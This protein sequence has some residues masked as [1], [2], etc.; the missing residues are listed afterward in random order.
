MEFGPVVTAEIGLRAGDEIAATGRL[1]VHRRDSRECPVNHSVI[2][3]VV[4]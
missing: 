2:G 1:V 3:T 4:R